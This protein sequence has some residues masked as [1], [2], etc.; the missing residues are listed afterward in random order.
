M[1]ADSDNGGVNKNKSQANL[2]KGVSEVNQIHS[3]ICDYHISQK[4]LI[5]QSTLKTFD[6]AMQTG[7]A[8]FFLSFLLLNRLSDYQQMTMHCPIVIS[9]RVIGFT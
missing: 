1:N 9:A 3:D 4:K 8:N 6:R 2:M 7:K 5:I